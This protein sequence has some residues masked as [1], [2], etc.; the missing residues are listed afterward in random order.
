M[1]AI[2][3]PDGWIKARASGTNGGNCVEMMALQ[4]GGIDVRDSKNPNGVRLHFTKAEFA[5]WLDGA[6]K[7]EFDHLV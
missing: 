1:S 7:G 4:D 5:A 3:S 6:R 2:V